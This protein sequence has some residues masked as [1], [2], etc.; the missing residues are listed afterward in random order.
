MFR[1]LRASLLVLCVAALTATAQDTLRLRVMTLNLH[2]GSDASLKRIAQC[3]DSVHPDL[4]A[5][6][7]V[8]CFTRRKGVPQQNGKDFIGQLAFHTG[9]FGAY[10]KTIRFAGGYYGIGLLSRHPLVWTRKHLLPNPDPKKEQ[11]A[12]LEALVEL[13]CGDSV[14][15]A[16]THLEAFSALCR[17]AQG[18]W[19]RDYS[20]G[21]NGYPAIIGGDFNCTPSDAVITDVMNSLWQDVSG[22][23]LTFPASSPG[24]K[25]DYI[26]ARPKDKW[27]IT[28]T[29]TVPVIISDHLPVVTSIELV[30]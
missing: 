1:L 7:E 18:D 2:F 14:I 26:F 25:I 5:L 3:I 19:L 17:T 8:D 24:R 9:M 6:Q 15:F 16:S 30:R 12:L 27:T 13:P 10:G 22:D 29:H 23:G 28:D 4:V 11:R 21:L 20:L